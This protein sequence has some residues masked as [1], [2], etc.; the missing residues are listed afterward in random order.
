MDESLT[1][2]PPETLSQHFC[3]LDLA[4]VDLASDDGA[5]GY[6]RSQ[7]LSDGESESS[8]SGSGTSS[9]KK[10]SSR[11]LFELDEGGDESTSLGRG[12]EEGKERE[13]SLNIESSSAGPR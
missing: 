9:E 5:E 11:E 10:S 4:R 2:S 13:V 7:L 6:F 8:L 1:N 3:L 12:R